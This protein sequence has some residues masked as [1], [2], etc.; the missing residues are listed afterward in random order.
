MADLETRANVTNGGL[1][2]VL[3][4]AVR[5]KLVEAAGD[6]RWYRPEKTPP[7]A[8][9]LAALLAAVARV[10]DKLIEPLPRRS[11]SRRS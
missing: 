9:P 2:V 8:E 5:L 10:P 3:P 7:I 4:G 11:Y 1:K 6:N